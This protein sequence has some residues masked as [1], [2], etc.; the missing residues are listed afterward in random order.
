MIQ[1]LKNFNIKRVNPLVVLFVI[2]V[3]MLISFIFLKKSKIELNNSAYNYTQFQEVSKNYSV[4][5][6]NWG[7]SKTAEKKL[8]KLIKSSGIKNI[9]VTKKNK[10]QVIK[11]EYKQLNLV[12]QFINKVLNENLQIKKLLIDE[13][14]VELEIRY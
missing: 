12:D 4:L 13:K 14:K 1:D 7:D 11:F 5:K 8:D 9:D 3:L 2:F 6:K 10:S